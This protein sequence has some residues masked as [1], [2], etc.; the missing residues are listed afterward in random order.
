MF[1]KEIIS[2][3]A[4]ILG[5]SLLGIN[6]VGLFIPLK[7]PAI[8]NEQKTGSIN[9]T[10]ITYDEAMRQLKTVPLQDVK[11]YVKSINEII[12]RGIAHYWEDSGIKKYNLTIPLHE[13]YILYALSYVYPDY[14]KYEFCQY[15]K[16][17]ERGVGLCSQQAIA[18]TDFLNRKGI[19]TRIVSLGGHVVATAKVDEK[20]NEW[21][22]LGPDLNVV[23]P[24]SIEKLETS[25]DI[26]RSYYRGKIDKNIGLTEEQIAEIYGKEGNIIYPTGNYGYMDCNWKKVFIERSSYFL[27]WIIPILLILP[28]VIIK[29][30]KMKKNE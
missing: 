3:L 21:W 18:I 5:L 20:N 11:Q 19:E 30:N 4:F 28:Y 8:Y 15:K 16:A 22:V 7:N 25:P 17:L 29:L 10:T 1:K 6:T 23:I 2:V 27:I 26:V 12:N 13:N 24:Y 9:D 14:K